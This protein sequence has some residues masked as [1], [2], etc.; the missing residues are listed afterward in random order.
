MKRLSA[1]LIRLLQYVSIVT[2]CH[3]SPGGGGP[4][5]LRGL[6][7]GARGKPDKV[8]TLPGVLIAPY[9]NDGAELYDIACAACHGKK[10]EGL[11]AIGL[12]GIDISKVSVRSFIER[13]ITRS[14]MPSFQGHPSLRGA[15]FATKQS[16]SV[17][18]I[19]SQS[20]LAMTPEQSR[21]LLI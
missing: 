6:L 18:E 11:F 15:F 3:V 1:G 2:T 21:R 16:P 10:A 19:A 7:W 14:G 4:R 17:T 13:G 8:P 12:V 9:V 5:T 20:A